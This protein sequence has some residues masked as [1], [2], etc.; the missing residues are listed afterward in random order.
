MSKRKAFTVWE[1]LIVVVVLA[2]GAAILIPPNAFRGPSPDPRRAQCMSNLKQ[3]G[4]AFI[5]YAQDADEKAP[6]V[7]NAR[8][9]WKSLVFPY[10]KSEAIFQC[11]STNGDKTGTTDYFFNARLAGAQGKLS[12]NRNAKSVASTITSGDGADDANAFSHLSQLP[13]AWRTDGN[14]PAYRHLNGANYLFID[15]HVKWFKPQKITL[16]KPK[17]GKPTFLAK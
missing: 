9:G 17:G 15:G 1:V 14:S 2:V 8:G 16:D 4:L 7:A 12:L 11:R 10:V 13:A 5:Q 3:L 6:P